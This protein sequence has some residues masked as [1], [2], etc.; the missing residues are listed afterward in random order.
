MTGFEPA[1]FCTQ[2]KRATKLRY[3]PKP[4]FSTCIVL[5]FFFFAY[6]FYL[7]YIYFFLEKIKR[8]NILKI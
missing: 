5:F 4:F 1:T 7:L 3:I 6:L 2:N 8:K